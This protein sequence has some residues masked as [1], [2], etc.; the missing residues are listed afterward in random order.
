M[1]DRSPRFRLQRRA[2]VAFSMLALA[3]SVAVAGLSYSL[4][5][6]VLISQRE[7]SALQQTFLH[8]RNVREGLR[9]AD[10]E[11]GDVLTSL[12]TGKSSYPLIRSDERWFT[13][14]S[15]VTIGQEDI[16]PALQNRTARG[17]A[18][19]QRVLAKGQTYFVVGVPIPEQKIV[20][21]EAFPLEELKKTLDA[22][23][24]ALGTAAAIATVIGAAVGILGTRRVVRPLRD[25]AVAA[26]RIARGDL[27]ARLDGSGDKSL[28][29]LVT[30]F[31]DMASALQERVDRD[32]RFASNVSHELRSP[33][34]AIRASLGLVTSR[35]DSMPERAR[36]GVELLEN[37]VDRFERMVLDLLD[38][39]KLDGSRVNLR[40]EAVD[41]NEMVQA[42]TVGI[43]RGL[44]N[45]RI[46]VTV[47]G[48]PAIIYTDKRFLE[49]V[50]SNIIDNAQ[51]HGRGLRQ[52]AI[53]RGVGDVFH[54]T[55][56]DAG[57]GVPEIERHRIFERFARGAA[58]RH[59]TGSG[60]G[61]ALVAEYSTLLGGTISV[62]S[63]DHGGARFTL[64]LPEELAQ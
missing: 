29:P 30:S 21:F 39:S 63:S 23:V 58:A 12:A 4:A 34:T 35:V 44:E 46:P 52:V 13:G 42:L 25:L 48:G 55:F 2:M 28:T 56:D 33:L 47:V 53:T 8:A 3:A 50:I 7:K 20:Y 14:L 19:R 32:T 1:A 17:Q 54:V 64:T 60:L 9:A 18:S 51:R 61:L 37:Q 27:S 10:G 11:Y 38:I 24:V 15:Q 62:S 40:T 22:L 41:L 43:I 45:D 26:N 49:R 36:S 16:S 57:P 6:K 5:R 59:G 31:N